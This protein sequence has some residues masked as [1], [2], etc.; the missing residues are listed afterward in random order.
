LTSFRNLR[1]VQKAFE[2]SGHGNCYARRIS[3]IQKADKVC[4]TWRR[5]HQAGHEK[6]AQLKLIIPIKEAIIPGKPFLGICLGLQLLF[7]TSEEGGRLRV[8]GF[9][10]QGH[11]L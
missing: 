5:C 10:R 2:E 3:D 6:L 11:A 4:F 7:D 9:A 1:S 8:W